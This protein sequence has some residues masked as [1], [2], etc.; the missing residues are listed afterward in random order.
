MTR[1][2]A[3]QIILDDR[4]GDCKGFDGCWHRGDW[5]ECDQFKEKVNEVLK[6][7]AEVSRR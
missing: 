1:K 3:K 7:E 5:N 4:C 6:E 2:E